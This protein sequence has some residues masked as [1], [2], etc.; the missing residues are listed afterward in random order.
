MSTI[1]PSMAERLT[2]AHPQ[3][4]HIYS[5]NTMA[6]HHLS[7]ELV[8]RLDRYHRGEISKREFQ[9]ESQLARERQT[10]QEMP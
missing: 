9:E 2:T 7:P 4:R 8:D 6:E 1:P 5:I 10:E 3:T